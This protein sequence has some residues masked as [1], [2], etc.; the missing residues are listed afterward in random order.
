MTV[1][2]G[3]IKLSKLGL[4]KVEAQTLGLGKL[5]RSDSGLLTHRPTLLSFRPTHS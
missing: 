1:F 3:R 4:E 5:S 2:K